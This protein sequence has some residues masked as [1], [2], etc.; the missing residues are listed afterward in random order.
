[1]ATIIR[2]VRDAGTNE[3][4]YVNVDSVRYLTRIPAT[5]TSLSISPKGKA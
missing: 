4:V 1:M 3:P 5:I 2:C